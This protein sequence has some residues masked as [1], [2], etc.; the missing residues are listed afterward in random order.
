[1]IWLLAGQSKVNYETEEMIFNLHNFCE[2][3]VTWPYT[4]SVH[5]VLGMHCCRGVLWGSDKPSGA[6]SSHLSAKN[7]LLLPSPELKASN[8]WWPLQLLWGSQVH[9]PAHHCCIRN[10]YPAQMS[11]IVF[12]TCASHAIKTEVS[13]FQVQQCGVPHP[14]SVWMGHGQGLKLARLDTDSGRLQGAITRT[15]S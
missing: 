8:A 3:K 15:S 11:A 5:L 12:L 10:S 14:P 13:F 4:V 2:A 9:M 1:M 7:L 6:Q